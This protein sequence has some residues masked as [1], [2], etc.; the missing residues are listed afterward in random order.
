METTRVK[1]FPLH[2]WIGLLLVIIF[3]PV[4]W[5]G[6]GTRTSW[7]FFPMWVGYALTLDALAYQKR[8][9]SLFSRSWK[10]YIG[11]FLISIPVWWVFELVN[12]RVQNWTYVGAKSFS[13]LA[14]FLLASFNFSVVIPAIFSTAEWI[15]GMEFIRK[16]G[17]G[18]VIKGDRRTTRAFFIAGVIMLAMLLVWPK[19]FFPFFW[20][21]IFFILEPLNIWLGFP[22]LTRYTGRGDWRPVIVLWCAVLL[23]GFFWEMW[24]YFSYP[25]W[26]Y[27]IPYANM[28]HV[29]EMPLLGYGGYLPFALE[30]YALYHLVM[31]IM[32]EKN[33]EYLHLEPEEQ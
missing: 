3:W 7:A 29:F 23:T 11:L 2:G 17:K 12:L 5:F 22:S 21:S 24:N 14:F 8:A 18:L 31:G 16:I 26:V 15:A 9:S 19:L 27:T 32:G 20:L 28:L 13:P 1:S 6:P 30:L 4:N 33:P 10:R 25:K